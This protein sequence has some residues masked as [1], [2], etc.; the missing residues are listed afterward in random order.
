MQTMAESRTDERVARLEGPVDEA[1]ARVD[2]RF[3]QIDQRFE[4]VDQRFEQ[5]DLRFEQVDERFGK[6][7]GKLESMQR[8]MNLRFEGFRRDQFHGLIAIC[9]V[10][11]AGF[12]G[13]MGLLATQL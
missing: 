7:E 1:F 6:L 2:Q 13:V 5:V 9:G 11:V 10:M 3:D 8:E 12:V 4:Q